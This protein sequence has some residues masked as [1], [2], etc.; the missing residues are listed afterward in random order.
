EERKKLLTNFKGYDIS[1]DMVRL[2]LVN[3]YLH[4]FVQPQIIEYDTLTS[5][6]RWNEYADVILANPPFM[7]PKGG[8]KPHK[9]FSVQSNRSEVLFVDYIAE[10]LTPT[11]RA[12][13]IVPEGIIFQSAT[14]YK[15]LRKMLVENYLYAVVSLPAGVFNPYSG[16]K[17]SILLM[18][19]QLAKKTDSILFVKIENDGFDLGAQRRPIDKN[20]LP[21]ALNVIKDFVTA[22]RNGKPETF[23]DSEKPCGRL[24]VKKEKIAENGEFNLIGDRY[25]EVINYSNVKWPIVK[26]GELIEERTERIKEKDIQVWTVSNNKGFVNTENYFEKKVTSESISNYKIVKKNYFAYNPA[27]INVKS[28]ALNQTE[29]EGCVSP[30]YVVFE[31]IDT[32]LD[33]KYLF[34]ILKESKEIYKEINKKSQGSVRIQLKYDDFATIQ[35]PLPPIEVQREIVAEIE[36]Y[37]KLIDGCRQ[38]V[39]SWKPQID[40]DP[41]W[42]VVR[43]DEVFTEIKNGKN[44]EQID[45]IGKYRVSRI[46]TISNGSFD[47]NKTKWTNNKV[48]EN[49]F[50]KEGDILLSHINSMEHLAK[51]A[52][53][54]N[55]QE[56]VVHGIN[57]ILFRPDINRI[58]PFF[59][60][61]IFKSK[62]FVDKARSF[63]QKAVNQAS[64]KITDLKSI[65][66]PLPP[67]SVQQEIVAKI[68]AEQKVIDGCREL[69]KT[70]EEKIKRVID[71]VWGE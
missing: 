17:T 40:I 65:Q 34:N 66:I 23:V 24:V 30:M 13:V 31:I 20:D 3:M 10:H 52:I 28:I 41:D 15:T 26:L 47:L 61:R 49:D 57:L 36:G 29:E 45:E 25:R 35:I 9:R 71:K 63:A 11:G 62:L 38:V 42:P 58:N 14:A 39:D 43:I 50:L 6:D 59:A 53:F 56:K 37:Q 21:D 8:I 67:L 18:D 19:K 16:V 44:V 55:I 51:A 4:G 68:E 46:Q 32:K 70:Y 33:P 22:L 1:P 54:T 5:E 69:I 2:S 60:I 12:A 64:I 27:R 48:D 7:T